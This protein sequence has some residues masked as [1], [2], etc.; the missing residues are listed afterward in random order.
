LLKDFNIN[1]VDFPDWIIKDDFINTS[2][3]FNFSNK[4]IMSDK[5]LNWEISSKIFSSKN[6]TTLNRYMWFIW[7]KNFYEDLINQKAYSNFIN[8]YNN[9]L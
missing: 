9:Y 8:R 4:I 1:F 6:F 2:H 7:I 3:K 5:L